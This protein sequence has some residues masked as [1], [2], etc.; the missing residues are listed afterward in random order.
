VFPVKKGRFIFVVV[1]LAMMLTNIGLVIPNKASGSSLS[2]IATTFNVIN[3]LVETQMAAKDIP[4]LALVITLGDKIV[5][6]KGFGVTSLDEPNKVTPQTVFDL[7]SSSKS[8]TALAVLLLRDKGL[9]DLDMPLQHYLPNF[10]LADADVSSRITVAQLLNHTSGLTAGASDPLAYQKG[11]DAMDKMVAGLKNVH[12]NRSPGESFEYANLNYCLLGAVV[13][14]VSG[15]PFED[16][17]KQSIFIPL[18]MNNTT[19]SPDEAASLDKADGHQPM[20]GRVI[21]RNIPVYR[22]A[23]PAGWV[24]SSA[25]DMGRW[26]ILNLNG[27]QYSGQQYIPAGN[28]EDMHTPSAMLNREGEEAGYGMGWFSV[29]VNDISLIWHGGDTPNFSTE[30]MLVPEHK[31]GVMVMV[32]SQNNSLAHSIV[33]EIAGMVLGF[34]INLPLAPWWASWGM[35]DNVATGLVILDLLLILTLAVYLWWLRRQVIQGHRQRLTW[36]FFTQWRLHIWHTVMHVSPLVV[37]GTIVL[38]IFMVAQLFFGFDPYRTVI[39]FREFAPPSIWWSTILLFIAVALWA[40][41]LA[42]LGLTFLR[43]KS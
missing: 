39:D 26:L 40:L 24:M 5:H 20:F 34:E 25:E 21:V 36:P 7:A 38:A 28:F 19:V 14:K 37:L 10:K 18:G 33:P 17:M 15:M 35:I 30:M 4:G 41:T 3:H 13:E 16:F 1:V 11:S 9:I 42:A 6:V 8:F 31:L 2:Q 32:N 23:A 12:L 29:S 22:S 27:G 43:G